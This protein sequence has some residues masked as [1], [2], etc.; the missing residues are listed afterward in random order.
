MSSLS[1]TGVRKS[2]TDTVAVDDPQFR[3][4][5]VYDP[6]HVC[7]LASRAVDDVRR[8]EWNEHGKSKTP[9][10]R[11]LCCATS[12]TPF[13]SSSRCASLTRSFHRDSWRPSSGPRSRPCSANRSTRGLEFFS[14]AWC[15]SG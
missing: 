4:E 15:A 3:A 10:G 5:I 11:W 13:P 6:F 9:G 12:C 8:A 1:V 14:A 2:F 7:Q